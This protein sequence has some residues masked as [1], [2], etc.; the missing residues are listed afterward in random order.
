MQIP[1]SPTRSRVV[2]VDDDDAVREALM[3]ALELEGFD[4]EDLGSG[5]ALVLFDL[6]KAGVCLV[7]DERL[8]GITGLDA[9][10]RL[11]LRNVQLPAVLITSHPHLNL[12]TEAR[13]AGVAILEKP[14]F[15]DALS[16][17]IRAA[18]LP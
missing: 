17:A 4:V 6:P 1:M 13:L 9:L 12:R 14:L 11:Q 8:P 18:M 15:G 5:E 3:F 10:R 7:V 16:D 2:I